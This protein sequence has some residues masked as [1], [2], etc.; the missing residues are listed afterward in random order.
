MSDLAFLM[1]HTTEEKV[2]AAGLM[3]DKT[4][5]LA[6][7]GKIFGDV[8]DDEFGRGHRDA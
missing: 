6:S 1:K 3:P 7:V 5:P 8:V 2:V 4:T